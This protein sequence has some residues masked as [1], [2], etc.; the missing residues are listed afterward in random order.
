M[1]DFIPPPQDR[2]KQVTLSSPLEYWRNEFVPGVLT[3]EWC[4]TNTGRLNHLNPGVVNM[5]NMEQS[6]VDHLRKHELQP[7]DIIGSYARRGCRGKGRN[8]CKSK[9]LHF[10]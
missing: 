8:G 10:T 5:I 7:I 4:H 9:Q 6:T 2:T 1:A 3:V